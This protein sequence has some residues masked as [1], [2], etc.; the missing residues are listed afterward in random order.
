MRDKS[1]YRMIA[2]ALRDRIYSG[3]LVSGEK[4]YTRQQLCNL[5]NISSMT[6]FNVQKQ[7]QNAGLIFSEPGV[8]ILQ[9]LECRR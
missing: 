9:N 3:E 2:D 7:L 4:F 5:Y 1:K 6:A 8:E